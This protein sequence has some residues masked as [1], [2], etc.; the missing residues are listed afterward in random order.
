MQTRKHE[1]IPFFFNIGLRFVTFRSDDVSHD[2]VAAFVYAVP[3][4][5][6]RADP[7]LRIEIH[8]VGV[9][10]QNEIGIGLHVWPR[11]VSDELADQGRRLG[12][13][14]PVKTQAAMDLMLWIAALRR[15][16]DSPL[17][18]AWAKWRESRGGSSSELPTSVPVMLLEYSIGPGRPSPP[19]SSSSSSSSSPTPLALADS[20]QNVT[21]QIVAP[22]AQYDGPTQTST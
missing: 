15:I 4:L 22:L 18:A 16:G 11:A 17:H 7:D 1:T 9:I 13:A 8:D 3:W 19:S 14:N 21:I 20:D 10:A 12:V 5:T 6:A 2:D